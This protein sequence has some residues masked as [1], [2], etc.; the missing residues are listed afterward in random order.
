VAQVAEAATWTAHGI[1]ARIADLGAGSPKTGARLD[2]AGGDHVTCCSLT[3]RSP[4]M[5]RRRPTVH[6]GFT[7][8]ELLVVVAIISLLIALLLPAVQQA[9]EAARRTQCSNNLK[10][11]GL[12]LHNY[13]NQ[14]GRF[15]TATR[16]VPGSPNIKQTAALV[17]LLPQLDQAALYQQYNFNVNWYDAPN[18]SLIPIQLTAFVCPTTPYSSR[19][20]STVVTTASGAFSGARACA[21]YAPL[22]GVGSL[23]TGTGLIDAPSQNSPGVLQ[24]NFMASRIADIIDGTSSTMMIA[25]DAGRP[26]WY[27]RGSAAG[28]GL[29]PPGAGWA[30]DAQDFLLHGAQGDALA[31]PPGPCAVN[32]H[33]DG[34]IYSFH[35]GVANSL[36]GDG[37]SK[38]LSA[39]TDIRVVARLITPRS[40]ELVGEY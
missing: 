9:R 22:E 5:M 10:Q 25:E 18:Q 4:A 6:P 40:Q 19:T 15:P 11:I 14:F 16:P 37:H 13:E 8:I 31:T 3:K 12:A 20:D 35:T 21:D 26:E 27:I 30:D 39:S 23:L 24:V 2:A 17:R 28:T 38:F 36:F 29:I 32:C 33:N 1:A 34:E 7:L